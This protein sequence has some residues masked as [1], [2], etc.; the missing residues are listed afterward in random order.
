MGEAV[1]IGVL[2]DGDGD[3]ETAV[4]SV[5]RR[6]AEVEGVLVA[7]IRRRQLRVLKVVGSQIAVAAAGVSGAE[8]RMVGGAVFV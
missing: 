5:G 7:R 3:G 8:G 4:V 6:V 2:K 1:R